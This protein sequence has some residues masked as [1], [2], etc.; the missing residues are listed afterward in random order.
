MVNNVINLYEFS[1]S[2][3]MNEIDKI[4]L[5]YLNKNLFEGE[6]LAEK[7]HKRKNSLK[8]PRENRRKISEG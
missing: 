2:S 4:L 3:S 5:P 1:L 6:L 7:I 8:S